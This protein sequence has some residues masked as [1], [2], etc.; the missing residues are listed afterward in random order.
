[1][2]M[3]NE[4]QNQIIKHDLQTSNPNINSSVNTNNGSTDHANSTTDIDNE[5]NNISLI[6]TKNSN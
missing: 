2:A 4:K 5:P 6:N 1:M 3:I